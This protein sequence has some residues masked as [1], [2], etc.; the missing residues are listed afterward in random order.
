MPRLRW[1]IFTACFFLIALVAG[2]IWFFEVRKIHNLRSAIAERTQRLQE[3]QA[4]V[5]RFSDLIEFYETDEGMA[6]LG[7]EHFNLVFKGERIFILEDISQDV[8]GPSL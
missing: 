3:K 1:I 7:R 2:T 8:R 5:S 6:Y 4:L